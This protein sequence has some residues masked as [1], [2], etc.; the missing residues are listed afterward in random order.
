M[1]LIISIILGV[2][3][4]FFIVTAK[5]AFN[6]G[7]TKE[8]ETNRGSVRRRLKWWEDVDGED[9]LLAAAIGAAVCV[10]N[11]TTPKLYHVNLLFLAPVFLIAMLALLVWLMVWWHRRGATFV[12]MIPFFILTFL[13]FLTAKSPAWMTTGL[14]NNM[15]WISVVVALPTLFAVAAAGFF[16]IDAFYYQYRKHQKNG[17]HVGGIIA[18]VITTIILIAIICTSIAWSS[19]NFNHPARVNSES[20]TT[21]ATTTGTTTGPANTTAPAA[22]TAPVVVTTNQSTVSAEELNAIQ[23]KLSVRKVTIEELERLTVEKYNGVSQV[24]LNSSLSPKDKERT[25]TTGFSD[26]LAFGFKDLTSKD[27]MFVELEEEI[28]RNPVY[29]L[30]VVNALIDKKIGDKTV[31]ELNPWMSEMLA[32]D[33]GVAYWLEYR[34]E[35]ETTMYVTDEFR[36]YAAT[37]CT[38]LE[39][40]VNQGVQIHQT[41]ENWCLNTVANNNDRKGIKAP[42]QYEREAL[43]LSWVTKD[44]NTL[45]S[46]GF[47]IHDKRPEFF[48]GTPEN[49]AIEVTPEPTPEPTPDPSTPE[50]TPTP[51]TPTP[52]PPTPT[53]TPQYT[54]DPS[55]ATPV[56]T[57]PGDDPGPDEDTN[58]GPGATE[59]PKD[60]PT[61]S[62]K[63]TYP[64]YVEEIRELEKVNQSQ[65]TG[66]DPSTPS[67]PKPS[68]DTKVD[69]NG[70]T[71]TENSAPINNPT[72][73]TEPAKEAGSG[74]AISDSPGEPWGGPPD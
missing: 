65:K 5:Q 60:Q 4:M 18:I 68:T 8:V 43:I 42:Y 59:S 1:L 29:T 19:I 51:P 58:A 70:D 31:G 49:P 23:Q 66:D 54:K 9:W 61:N 2:K 22:T 74:N 50:P 37:L 41:T 30:T 28:L 63:I 15:F 69:N 7:L 57:E 67:T 40:L 45:L 56:N 24:F 6:G 73:V 34:D 3:V 20:G 52:A 16:V 13:F 12:E 47:N 62:N 39:R 38:W 21:A 26:A 27:V 44:G 64:E 10:I 72:Q 35:A 11:F 53:P 25:E 14:W 17:A 32:K 46:V 48:G 33:V 71:G 55:K 36:Q